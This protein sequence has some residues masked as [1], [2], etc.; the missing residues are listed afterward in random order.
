MHVH[1]PKALGGWRD[2][3][4]EVGIIVVGVLIALGAE[5]LAQSI[6]QR[7]EAADARANVR[8][9]TALNMKFIR[10]RVSVQPCIDRRIADLSGMLQRAG[11]GS[12]ERQPTWISAPPTNPFFDRRWQ[13]ANASGR[14]SLFSPAEQ[15]DFDQLYGIFERLNVHEQREQ[16]VWAN[17]RALE[18]WRGTLGPEARLSFA[19]DLKQA[20]Y[21]AWDL[22]I[23]DRLALRNP[24]G[25]Q[26]ARGPVP[27]GGSGICLSLFTPTDEALRQVHNPFGQP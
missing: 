20:R 19:R 18:N 13:A 6:H 14:N 2:F 27:E 4:K 21:F 17:L 5:Q 8:A 15:E 1:L 9:E 22:N 16:E 24:T 25:A 26:L 23:A 10:Y 11:D 12:M 3:L 7:Q